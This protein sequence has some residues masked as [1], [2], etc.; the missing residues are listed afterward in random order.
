M[1]TLTD[2]QTEFQELVHDPNN[3]YFSTSDM[4]NYINRARLRV[5]A[6]GQ[7][8]R[9][10][11][12]G[13]TITALAIVSGG[14][15][16]H[17]GAATVTISGAG[18][19]ATA[20]ASVSGLTLNSITLT[21][22]GWG[23]ITGT[24]TT[25]S[26]LDSAGV[27]PSVAPS[28]TITVDNSLTTVP[29]QEVY[30]FSLA[31]TLVTAQSLFTGIASA[32]GLISVAGAWGANAA[33]KPMLME[34]IWSE[35]QAYYRSYNT[36]L[37]SYPTIW[38]KYGQG[39]NGSI[40]LWPLPSQFAQMDWD[41]WCLPVTLTSSST[42]EAIPY[43]Y[44]TPVAYYAAYLAF[45]NAQRPEDAKASLDDYNEKILECQPMSTGAFVGNYY[46]GYDY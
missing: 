9:F 31:N 5:A 21:N 10:L 1:T 42:P 33:M 39:L 23:Y 44:T 17:N 29:G 34:M 35:F 11:G 2:Y 32:E 18:Q 16:L 28:I 38:S 26:F 41:L 36:G 24:S 7:C 19:Q 20:T 15:F 22:G 45:K 37:Q 4:N 12:S 13:G 30:Q 43:P 25:I 40:Y 6:R 14:T 3:T 46:E 27:A 8:V